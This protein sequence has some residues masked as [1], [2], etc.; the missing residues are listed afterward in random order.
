MAILHQMQMN[1]QRRVNRFRVAMTCLLFA[2]LSVSGVTMI[3]CG[4][5]K[6]GAKQ[7]TPPPQNAAGASS[8]AAGKQSQSGSQAS[9][10]KSQAEY[11]AGYNAA[12]APWQEDQ[13][14]GGA[15]QAPLAEG[16]MVTTAVASELGDYESIKTVISKLPNLVQLYVSANIPH[17]PSSWYKDDPPFRRVHVVG[18]YGLKICSTPPYTSRISRPARTECGRDQPKSHFHRMFWQN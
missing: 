13:N 4:P 14:L 7:T 8:P 10:P 6:S 15:N 16:M 11:E 12:P 9:K 3:G 5:G 2:M 17:Q 18:G 1:V